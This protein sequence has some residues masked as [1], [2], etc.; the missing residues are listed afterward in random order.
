[1]QNQPV[2][3]LILLASVSL[4]GIIASQVYWTSRAVS[5]REHEFNHRVRMSLRAV[6]ES[7]C[8]MNGNDLIDNNPIDQVTDNYFIVRTQQNIDVGALEY[9]IS[10]EFDKRSINQDFE[11][12]VY[13]CETNRMVYGNYVG[14][15]PNGKIR[16][17]ALPVLQEDE[18][19][20]GVHFP[21][22]KAGLL[23][24]MTL[25]KYST[26]ATVIMLLI[27]SYGLF[28]VLRQR[29]LS[30]M[31]N[32]FIDN[33]THEL[34]T[35]LSSLKL[36]AEAVSKNPTAERIQQYA[37][38]MVEET[39]RLERQIKDLLA[40][41]L[42]EKKMDFERKP[43]FVKS[44]LSELMHRLEAEYLHHKFHLQFHLEDALQ[45]TTNPEFLEVCIRN[46]VDNAVKY[47][48]ENV[49]LECTADKKYITI[50]IRDDGP[51]IPTKMKK[52]I[53]EKFYRIPTHNIHDV[54]GYGLGLYLVTR[55]IRRLCG[56][57]TL[58]EK[59]GGAA[60][61]IKLPRT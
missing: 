14:E 20:F 29:K 54:K 37:G 57:L 33:V 31:Q 4:V 10:G 3:L 17:S 41:S 13:N 24:E 38:I 5:E 51:G 32:D 26:L 48:K 56:K 8:E 30:E 44:F 43:I 34:K 60:F 49:W 15:L 2:R 6:V 7:L 28:V 25:W 16:K 9:L 40:T 12:G 52:R 23:S 22:K 55:H 19:Y 11:Y 45:L 59:A 46:L 61:E 50:E 58:L 18:Y 35:P 47:G 27:L 36:A 42:A 53:F 39:S 1:M 21:N